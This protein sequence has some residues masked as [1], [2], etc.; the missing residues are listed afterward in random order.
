MR[1]IVGIQYLRGF[2]ATI[3]VFA[4]TSGMTALPKYFDQA[5][6]EEFLHAGTVG[7]DLFF[8]I[9]GFIITITSLSPATLQPTLSFGEFF[10]RRFIRIVPF[11]WACVLLYAG[12]RFL[13]RGTFPLDTYVNALVL[14]PFGEVEP[15]QIWTLRDEFLFYL[16]FGFAMLAGRARPAFLVVWMAATAGFNLITVGVLDVL[17]PSVWG[18][19]ARAVLE[20]VLHPLHVEFGFGLALGYL[21]LLRPEWLRPTLPGGSAILILLVFALV[22]AAFLIRDHRV[23]HSTLP[24]AVIL[25]AVAMAIA[26]MG[27]LL[28]RTDTIV[29]KA[30]HTLGDASYAIYLTHTG[31]VSAILGVW[32]KLLPTTPVGIVV[33]IAAIVATL[34]GVGA[35]YVLERPVI[36][37]AKFLLPG[38]RAQRPAVSQ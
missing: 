12:L 28:L 9:S 31:F 34:L 16:L 1:D 25:G 7:V 20:F 23:D 6:F 11:L 3:V 37:V 32:S 27:I 36:A 5:L 21:Y 38:R 8:V 35:H 19:A 30:S 22:A 17:F 26:A 29:D 24:D 13:G 15:N 33:P 4:H 18:H 2:A 10:R 14:N